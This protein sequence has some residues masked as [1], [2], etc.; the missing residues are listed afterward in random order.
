M[1]MT[2]KLPT[3]IEGRHRAQCA[4]RRGGPRCTCQPSYR[5]SISDHGRLLRGPWRPS[6]REAETW[7]HKALQER[8]AGARTPNEI[9]LRDAWADWY[10]GALS[11]TI[12]NRRGQRYKPSAL[13]GYERAWRIRIDAELGAHRV[14]DIQREDL[15]ALVDRLAQAGASRS[16]INNTLDP[17]RVIFRRAVKRRHIAANPTL[18]LEL[19]GEATRAE[20]IATRE[21]A[22][23]L[24]DALPPDARALW[25]TALYGGLRRGELRALRWSDVDLAAGTIRVARAWD[26]DP[27]VGEIEPKTKGSRRTVP[28]VPGLAALLAAHR[29]RTGRAGSDLVFGATADRPFEPSTVRRRALA[30]WKTAERAPITLHG[31]RHTAASLMIAAGANAKA[32]STVMGHAGIEITF[33]R[34]GHLMPGSEAEVGD[35]LHAYLVGRSW[36]VLHPTAA[37]HGGS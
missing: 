9:T 37:V 14:A 30:A 34:Y 28:I 33:N 16:T 12:P 5:A 21:E 23:A 4:T 31:A 10:A 8:A 26:D 2:R 18:E 13:R 22:A 24:I 19:P 25:A 20:R 32:L 3:G 11:G 27:A 15:Q 7:R 35:R 6:Q 1:G 36:E 17:V 29:D